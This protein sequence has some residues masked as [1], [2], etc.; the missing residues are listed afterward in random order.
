MAE[1]SYVRIEVGLEGGQILS[2]LVTAP[3]ADELARAVGSAANAALSL[4]A[5]DGTVQ[6]VVPRVLYVKRFAREGRVGFGD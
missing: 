3:S 5:Q 4:D 2:A 1:D 6:V